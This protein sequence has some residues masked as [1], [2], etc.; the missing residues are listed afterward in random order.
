MDIVDY[1]PFIRRPFWNKSM[2]DCYKRGCVCQGCRIY[3]LYFEPRKSKCFMKSALIE[4]IR[5]FGLPDE[6]QKTNRENFIGDLK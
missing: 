4:M 1:K 5:K 3:H 6:L 2:V